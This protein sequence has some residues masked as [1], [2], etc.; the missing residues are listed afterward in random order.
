MSPGGQ[1]TPIDLHDYLQT[2]PWPRAGRPQKHSLYDWTIGDNW[3]EC[4]PVTD[5]EVDVFEA[6]FGDIF[7]QLL[8]ARP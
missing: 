6:W 4:I 2:E 8:G 1:I 7:D 3:P 5:R